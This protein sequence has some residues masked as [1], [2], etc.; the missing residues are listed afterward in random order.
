MSETTDQAEMVQH[1][2][3]L[4]A[5]ALALAK[6]LLPVLQRTPDLGGARLTTAGVLRIATLRGLAG[7]KDEYAE[8]LPEAS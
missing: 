2:N 7:L 3:W 1:S 6:E 8:D 5:W 4:P